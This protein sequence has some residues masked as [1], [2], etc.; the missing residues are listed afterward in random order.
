VEVKSLFEK[1]LRY[2]SLPF[3]WLADLRGY[4]NT[5]VL[6]G[7]VVNILH[8]IVNPQAAGTVSLNEF[9]FQGSLITK[10]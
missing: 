4:I 7:G 1:F 2:F 9:Y 8:E 6:S 5:V 10:N 3:F